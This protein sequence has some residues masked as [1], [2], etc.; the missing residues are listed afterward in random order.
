MRIALIA[1]V[2]C[3]VIFFAFDF[4]WL[5]TVALNFYRSQ[6]GGLLMEKP[7]LPVAAAFY[8][9]YV[10]GLVYFCVLPALNAGS[11]TLALVNGA[12][13]GFFAYA[14]YDLTNLSTLVNW[15][16]AVSVVDLIWG[17]VVSAAT[18]TLGFWATG[19]VDRLLR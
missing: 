1:Y 5:G 17:T 14:T 8:A 6:L 13:F 19:W 12:L 9:L 15:S 11:W 16:A 3:L 4:V 2:V 18:A 10:I 7:N